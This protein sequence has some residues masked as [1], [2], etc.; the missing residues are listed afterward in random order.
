M[1]YRI[2]YFFNAVLSVFSLAFPYITVPFLEAAVRLS[3]RSRSLVVERRN[4]QRHPAA[5]L[6]T[7]YTQE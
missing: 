4:Q 1:N 3:V 5:N 2:K 7:S 6:T